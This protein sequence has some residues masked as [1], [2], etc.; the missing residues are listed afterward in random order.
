MC[1]ESVIRLHLHEKNDYL[2]PNI[3]LAVVWFIRSER[4]PKKLQKISELQKSTNLPIDKH[5]NECGGLNQWLLQIHPGIII[6]FFIKEPIFVSP[7]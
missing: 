1:L 5:R 3:P 6:T 2:G 7:I 4:H